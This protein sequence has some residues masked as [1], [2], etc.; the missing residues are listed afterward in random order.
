[1]LFGTSRGPHPVT[2]HKG[3][4]EIL[5]T[6]IYKLDSDGTIIEYSNDTFSIKPY[7]WNT[8]NCYGDE[9]KC[10]VGE[11]NFLYK[12]IGFEMRWYKYPLRGS[13]T[14]LIISKRTFKSI[15]DHCIES[16]GEVND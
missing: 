9:C 1:M 6:L 16:V 8:C 3:W 12:P 4:E 15:I 5:Y 10:E 2:R 14:N 13:Y 7:D 11:P